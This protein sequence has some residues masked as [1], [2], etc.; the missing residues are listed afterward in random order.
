MNLIISFGQPTN[1]FTVNLSAWGP[2]IIGLISIGLAWFSYN[3][4]KKNLEQQKS[5]F[6]IQLK[7]EQEQFKKQLK[8]QNQ[9]WKYD[10]LFKYR[11]DKLL[12]FRKLY[13]QFK[14]D[15]VE[16]L[17]LFMPSSMGY[18]LLQAHKLDSLTT[19]DIDADLRYEYFKTVFYHPP[20]ELLKQ[21]LKNCK[22]LVEFIK[23]ND[24]FLLDDSEFFEDIRALST[25][26]LELYEKLNINND[27]NKLFY[28]KENKYILVPTN[29]S[30]CKFF[31]KFMQW[32]LHLKR[33]ET[34]THLFD[35]YSNSI[36]KINK[37]SYD[38]SEINKWCSNPKVLFN[39]YMI[40]GNF[41]KNIEHYINAFFVK[42]IDQIK[43]LSNEILED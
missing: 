34:R 4:S 32:H 15:T 8:L 10:N 20:N 40:F 5:Q 33:G 3:L 30:F 39:T 14:T 19:L 13:K 16:F 31:Y 17:Q 2:V 26:F 36:I 21:Y 28:Q 35:L 6:E 7:N 23:E 43:E 9:Q 29:H 38:D 18:P 22:L 42:P 11:Q 41:L 12:E 25:A 27:L 37:L 1:D 24:L